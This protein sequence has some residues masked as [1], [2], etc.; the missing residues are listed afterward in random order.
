MYLNKKQLDNLLHKCFLLSFGEGRAWYNKQFTS[1][2]M[3]QLENRIFSFVKN[4]LKKEIK[5]SKGNKK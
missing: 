2:E 3:S 1:G 5:E 4:E